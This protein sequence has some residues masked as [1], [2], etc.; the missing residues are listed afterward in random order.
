MPKVKKYELNQL[1]SEEEVLTVE[2]K[3][4]IYRERHAFTTFA[5]RDVPSFKRLLQEKNIGQRRDR[6][7]RQ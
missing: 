4:Q 3:Q 7:D 2:D 5:M 6:K 1:L